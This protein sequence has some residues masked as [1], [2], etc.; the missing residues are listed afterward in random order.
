[1]QPV[2]DAQL[3]GFVGLKPAERVTG[4]PDGPRCTWAASS[5][6]R[7]LHSTGDRPGS[8]SGRINE[9]RYSAA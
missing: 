6:T 4:C 9:Y 7:R 1:M 8:A 2:A 5:R 3:V